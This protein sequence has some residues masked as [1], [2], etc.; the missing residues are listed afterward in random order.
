MATKRTKVEVRQ[1]TR[2][3]ESKS[4]NDL[5]LVGKIVATIKALD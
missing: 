4:V 2:P 1:T 3:I 5:I